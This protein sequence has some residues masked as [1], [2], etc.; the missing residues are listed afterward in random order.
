MSI[1]VG[2]WQFLYGISS[3]IV[4][5]LIYLL[6]LVVGTLIYGMNVIGSVLGKIGLDSL[7]SKD[8]KEVLMFLFVLVVL[9]CLIAIGFRFGFFTIVWVLF[10]IPFIFL[11]AKVLLTV[12]MVMILVGIAWGLLSNGYSLFKYK[13]RNVN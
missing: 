7:V 3:F 11:L 8:V 10:V 9:L 2:I 13:L 6:E 5:G 4:N 1:I 12:V